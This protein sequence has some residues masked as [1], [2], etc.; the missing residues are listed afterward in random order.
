MLTILGRS[1]RCCDGVNRRHFLQIGAL[2]ATLSLTDMLRA[3][4][5]HKAAGRMSRIKS[6]ILVYLPGGPSQ[7]D[8]FD[9]K[10]NAPR[11]IR[12]EFKPIQTNVPG[13]TICEHFPLLAKMFDKLAVLRSIVSEEGQ[14]SDSI[15]MTGHTVDGN[16]TAGHPSFGSVVSKLRGRV[17]GMPPFVSLRGASTGSEPGF[18]GIAHR[19]FTPGG[20][21]EANLRLPGEVSRQR[22]LERKRLLEALDDVRRDLDA[23]GTLAG[24]DSFQQQ[25]VDMVLSG[26]VR[27]ALSLSKEPAEV[28][29]R[30]EGVEQFLKARRLIEAG[31][32]CVSLSI[33]VWDTHQ[34]NFA[35]LKELLPLVDRG[36]TALIRDLHDR[37]LAGDVA[38][39]VWGEFGRTP[40]INAGAGRDHWPVMSA[41]MAGGGLKM[42]QAIGSTTAHGDQPRERPYSVAQVLATLYRAI[43]IDPGMTFPDRSG[44]PIYL[45]DDRETLRELT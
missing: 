45:L 29:E 11:E 24:M 42:G 40:K 28:L 30:Y 3:Q 34:N 43:G 22:L 17:W 32:G 16:K 7:L 21:E 37:G 38:T 10:P 36:L 6:A 14:H 1:L 19:P 39:I 2:G 31:V 13:I 9:L 41:L 15:V 26:K 33:G 4:A 12:G 44:R 35:Q 8:T 20:K 25:A 23:S 5:A 27:A 18:L